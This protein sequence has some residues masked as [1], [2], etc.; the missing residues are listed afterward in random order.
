M[1]I[2]GVVEFCVFPKIVWEQKHCLQSQGKLAVVGGSFPEPSNKTKIGGLS[3]PNP[4]GLRKNVH[5]YGG[6][7][8]VVFVGA[9]FLLIG[10]LN[11]I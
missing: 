7:T 8:V 9:M 4:Q 3:N 2:F 5:S 6:K 1:R 10:T 11:N